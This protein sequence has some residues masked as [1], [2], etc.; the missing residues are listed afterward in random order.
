[1]MKLKDKYGKDTKII[2]FFHPNCDAGAGGEKVLWSAVAAV[3]NSKELEGK[4]E[5]FI[6][7]GS[8]MN[9]EDILSEKVLKRFG[10]SITMDHLHF[11]TIDKDLHDSLDPKN[12]PSL[13]MVWQALAIIKVCFKSVSQSPCDVFI[14]TMGVGFSYPLLK[15][16]FGMKIYSYTHY[17]FISRDMIQTVATGKSQYNNQNMDDSVK[18]QVKLAYYWS[19]YYFYKFCGRSADVVAAN[20]SW[21]REHMDELWNKGNKIE[22]IYPPCDTSEFINRISLDPR[23]R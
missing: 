2:S 7:S 1:M 6:Y 14:D 3:Q 8:Q 22:T 18:K 21:T 17:P 4:V 16:V 19:I 23:M 13:T 10:I 5:V 15:W 9:P 20:S 11:E 12:Y